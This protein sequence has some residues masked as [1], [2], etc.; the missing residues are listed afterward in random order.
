MKK[1]A[2]S[3]LVNLFRQLLDLIVWSVNHLNV[4]QVDNLL[5]QGFEAKGSNAKN[6]KPGEVAYFPGKN[7]YT[8]F[9]DK[10]KFHFGEMLDIGGYF[11]NRIII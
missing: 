11:L 7:L 3:K 5:W 8:I 6:F 10:K 2:G 4:F 1:P 9:I